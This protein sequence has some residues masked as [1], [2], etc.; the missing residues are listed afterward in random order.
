MLVT[1]TSVSLLSWFGVFAVALML[2]AYA[3]EHIHHWFVLIF[4]AA[5]ILGAI[6]GFLVNAWPIGILLV[7]W[8][9][10]AYGRWHFRRRRERR[11]AEAD[12]IKPPDDPLHE[13]Q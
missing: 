7:A 9:A 10:I 6:Y 4:A 1:N 11:A 3:L 13:P 8:A 2:V 5:C 12:L